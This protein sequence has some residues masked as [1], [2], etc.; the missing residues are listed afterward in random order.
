VLAQLAAVGAISN[1][2]LKKRYGYNFKRLRRTIAD[3]SGLNL[4]SLQMLQLIVG[5][6]IELGMK[7]ADDDLS[8]AIFADVPTITSFVERKMMEQA[9]DTE[10]FL[11]G[12]GNTKKPVGFFDGKWF[13][14]VLVQ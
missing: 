13:A 6:E 5:L 7:I 8:P 1:N 10:F 11:Y 2:A 9:I 4:D 12:I 3:S 14:F